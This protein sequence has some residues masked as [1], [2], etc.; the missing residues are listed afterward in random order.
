MRGLT[1]KVEPSF[2]LSGEMSSVQLEGVCRPRPRAQSPLPPCKTT[3]PLPCSQPE[4]RSFAWFPAHVSEMW[5]DPF[6]LI[7]NHEQQLYRRRRRRR[8]VQ[9]EGRDVKHNF[10]GLWRPVSDKAPAP[11]E[12]FSKGLLECLHGI[13]GSVLW[14]SKLGQGNTALCQ[15]PCVQYH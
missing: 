8:S 11:Q 2:L 3:I 5:E 6:G 1:K 10:T 12:L 14:P 4:N 15:I 13:G 9:Q 7:D